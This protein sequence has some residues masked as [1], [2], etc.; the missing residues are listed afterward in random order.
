MPLIVEDMPG[1]KSVAVSWL[2]PAGSA[3][4]PEDRQGM[5][6]MW[7]E[8]LLRG[9]GDMDS[10]AMAD[11]LDRLGISRG[12]ETGT[13]FMSVSYTLLGERL[14]E[15]L[16]VMVDMVRRPR[17]DGDSIEPVRD[18]SL[19]AI[20]SLADDPH[21]RAMLAV[22]ERHNNPP[23]NRSPLGTAEG[24]KRLTRKDLMEGW[25]ARALPEGAILAVAGA[26]G[27]ADGVDGIACSM[28][29]LLK[30]WRGKAPAVSVTPSKTRGTYHHIQDKS[31]QV[32]IVLMH[33]APAEP[34]PDSIRERIVNSVLSGG[35]S[36]RL[37]TEVREKRGLCYSVSESYAADRDYGRCLAYVGTTPERA[38][39]SLDVLMNELKRINGTPP[40]PAPEPSPKKVMESAAAVELP[41]PPPPGITG[42]EFTTALVGIKSRIIFSG[43]STS[44][45]AHALASDHHKRGKA[46]SLDEISASYDALTLDQINEYL[47][48]RTLGP[49]TIVTLGPAALKA[50][51]PAAP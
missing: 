28:D 6:A 17:M 45:R 3:T 35:M 16:P 13:L 2:L 15:S 31:S 47:T 9:S 21:E 25:H 38:Q 27:A 32:Q 33:D 46:R 10:R 4:E 37:F 42:D 23:L 34:H 43:E 11:A 26:V 20:A 49:T 18:L 44:G 39:E 50:P 1:V 40:P 7:S 24:L 29:A 48:R 51:V 22:R 8:L 41:P 14:L 36:A 19:Q 5:G 30:G 12:A